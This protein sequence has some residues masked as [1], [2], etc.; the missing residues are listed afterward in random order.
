[1]RHA[2]TW[3][4][5]I[6][7]VDHHCHG[8]VTADLTRAA[9]EGL[10]SE[11]YRPAPPGTT[12]FQKPLGLAIRRHCAPLLDLEPLASADAYVERRSRLGTA[13]VNR[14]LLAATTVGT[15]LLDTGHR[16]AEITGVEQFA[17]VA[18][19]PT[20]EIVRIEA[21]AEEVAASGVDAAGFA[22]R[23]ADALRR[24]SEG[25]AGFKSIVAYRTTFRIDQT[26]PAAVE[27]E[28][29]AGR[30]LA[31]IGSTR[32]RISDPVLIR[33]GL[34]TAAEIARMRK[35]PIQLHVGFGDPDVYMHA[36]DPT[37]F[38]DFIRAM[39]AWEIPVTLLHNYPFIREAAWLSEVFQNVYYDVG[40]I[41]NFTGPSGERMVREA[42]EVG[43]F[44]KQVYSSDAFGLAELHYL[45]ALLFRRHLSAVLDGWIRDGE[46]TARDAEEIFAAIARD[47]AARIYPLA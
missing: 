35:L 44:T 33:H 27:V 42:L 9:L 31:S 2:D 11:S 29:A 24:R 3:T 28:R 1:L 8:V 41:V 17:Q 26:A 25:A 15:H 16:S 40:V 38:T 7:L 37:H 30:W 46:C 21:V 47:N 22:G 19:R 32:P 14:R 6:A 34:W 5:A 36:C 4:S 43:P 20:R 13:E 23:L 10:L 12:H 39:E 18:G 45:G